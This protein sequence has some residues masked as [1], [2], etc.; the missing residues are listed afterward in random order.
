MRGAGFQPGTDA[1]SEQAASAGRGSVA[2][3]GDSGDRVALRASMTRPGL[4]VLADQYAAGWSVTVDGRAMPALRTDVALRGVMV[5]AGRHLIVWTY[6]TPG[7][8]LGLVVSGLAVLLIAVWG[9][10]R[11]ANTARRRHAG[12]LPT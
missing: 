12:T 7:L 10:L 4:V 5:P 8:Q 11:L 1:V 3:V 6:E 9:L 2:I